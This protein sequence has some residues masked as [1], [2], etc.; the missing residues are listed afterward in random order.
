MQIL[1]MPMRQNDNHFTHVAKNSLI[2]L[3]GAFAFIWPALMNGYPLVFSDTSVFIAQPAPGFFNWDK[4]F[5]YGPWML[6]LHGWRSLWGVVAAQALLLS[7]L[8]WLATNAVADR[9]PLRH[10]LT[11]LVLGLVSTAPWFASF[12]MPDIFAGM[13][14]IA[15]FLLAFM[16]GLKGWMKGWLVLVASLAIA[17]HLSHLI[18]AAA[19]LCVVL[20]FRPTRFLLALMPMLLALLMLMAT[21]YVAFNV[22]SV[23]P[24]G[25]VFML[26]RLSAD[27]HT[28]PVLDK[29]CATKSWYLCQW[30][31][32]L[33]FDSD[34]FLWDGKGVVWSHPGGPIGL[35]PEATEIVRM[36]VTERPVQVFRSSVVNSIEQMRLIKLGDTLHADYLD[37]T[38]D[39]MLQ[40]Y[41]PEAEVQRF[42]EALQTRHSLVGEGFLVRL[43]VYN[44]VLQAAVLFALT[45]SLYLMARS[46]KQAGP[47]VV[48]VFAAFVA[49]AIATGALSKPQDRYQARISW[50]LF[51]PP[52]LLVGQRHQRRLEW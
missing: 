13:V 41:F 6:L 21:S 48:M 42:R 3:L 37:V 47:L 50:L 32:R 31:D 34:V 33:P 19:C 24:H 35:A 27:G 1:P 38:V 39:K 14:A 49:N 46:P 43:G 52:L 11:C 16:N 17:V 7:H 45:I 22:W 20:L 26:A 9:S 36:I 5:I 51:L 23:S 8:I 44:K 28:Q 15:L 29:Y 12:L 2:V 4:P 10:L 18:I 40:A 25:S 30:S